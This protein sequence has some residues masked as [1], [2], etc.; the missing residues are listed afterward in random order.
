MKENRNEVVIQS[1]PER[2]WETLTDLGK[3]PQWN[4]LLPRADGKLAM[5]EKVIL[6][7]R[8]ATK[9]MKLHC[10]VTS[11]EPKRQFSWKFHVILPFL[12]RGEHFF[13]IE[14]IDDRR[15]RFIDREVFTGLLLPLQARN[16][17]TNAKAGMVA[18]GE[19]LKQRAEN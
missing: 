5:G 9:D 13:K 10:T 3:Y 4:P 2:V 18:M 1:T 19:A 7:A 12:F 6:T 16:L 15:V 14:P 8:S 17:D 11:L